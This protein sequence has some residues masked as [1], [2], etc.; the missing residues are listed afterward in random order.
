MS[1]SEQCDLVRRLL[2]VSFRKV[3]APAGSLIRRIRW[4]TQNTLE[5]I[6]L[7]TIFINL[8]F[9]KSKRHERNSPHSAVCP[10]N[11]WRNRKCIWSVRRAERGLHI[12]PGG[13]FIFLTLYKQKGKWS[14]GLN[15]STA[16]SAHI[17]IISSAPNC[18]ER[19]DSDWTQPRLFW[20]SNDRKRSVVNSISI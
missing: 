12:A 1:D 7:C 18:V 19:R 9:D 5:L 16:M 10:A 4:V 11:V 6:Y 20:I 8:I 2:P 15:I 13:L 17:I 14:I 3:S